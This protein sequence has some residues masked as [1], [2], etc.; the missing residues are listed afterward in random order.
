MK[1]RLS[2]MRNL[3]LRIGDTYKLV[4]GANSSGGYQWSY[5]IV[6]GFDNVE[7]LSESIANPPDVKPGNV[8]PDTYE[9]EI[10]FTIKA[11]KKGTAKIKC[12]LSRIWEQDIPPIREEFV[13]VEI[14]D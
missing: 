13:I 4:F 1:G 8:M 10:I 3:K 2:V 9:A 7:I 6:T 12:F 14:T 5:C 11:I